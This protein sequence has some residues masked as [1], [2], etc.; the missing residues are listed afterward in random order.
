MRMRIL[1]FLF[2]L[3]IC[4]SCKKGFVYNTSSITD[5][6][7]SKS[8]DDILRFDLV[9]D[10]YYK[11]EKISPSSVKWTIKNASRVEVKTID[12]NVGYCTW[13]A[14]APGAYSIDA[15]ITFDAGEQITK[16]TSSSVT[17]YASIN[18]NKT[19]LKSSYSNPDLADPAFDFALSISSDYSLSGAIPVGASLRGIFYKA[20]NNFSGCSINID[21]I[22]SDGIMSGTITV[23]DSI[24]NMLRTDFIRDM[25]FYYYY[26]KIKFKQL[27][28]MDTTQYRYFDIERN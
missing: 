8:T 28:S 4:I 9:T 15:E 7:T 20:N 17:A 18:Y 12:Q 25:Q 14:P 6:N 1:F 22:N 19:L 5:A 13:K 21:K 16:Q 26:Y 11:G 27:Y 24:T 2:V 3:C 10:A 23:R